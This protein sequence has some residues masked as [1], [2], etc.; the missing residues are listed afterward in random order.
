MSKA[1]RTYLR[2]ERGRAARIAETVG[3]SQ[4]Y[5]SDIANGKKV[6]AAEKLVALSQATGIPVDA[7]LSEEAATQ[8]VP[9]V[10]WVSA[11]P[12]ARNE[13]V[14]REQIQE[15]VSVC[16]LPPGDWIAFR[17]EGSSMDRI[18]PPDSIILVN[19]RET[20]LIPNACYVIA[21]ENGDATYKRFRPDPDRFEPVSTEDKHQTIFPDNLPTVIGRVRRS[22]LSM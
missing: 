17:V 10:S 19:R 16:D 18:S 5:L 21:D 7:L 11:G 3:I 1:L 9:L 15:F 2:A 22:I 14:H 8:V 13:T 6:P 12:L 20:K 4:P